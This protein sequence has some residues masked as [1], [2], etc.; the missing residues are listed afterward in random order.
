[1]SAF[2]AVQAEH[3]EPDHHPALDVDDVLLGEGSHRGQVR[4]AYRLAERYTGRLLHVPRIGWYAWDGKRWAKDEK[5]A[6]T[7]AVRAADALGMIPDA[8]RA[9]FFLAQLT[10]VP[11][12][13]GLYS[14]AR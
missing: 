9:R 13:G 6:A 4:M 14:S 10:E 5:G 2:E 1:V 7:R 3:A 8:R 12:D 11:D